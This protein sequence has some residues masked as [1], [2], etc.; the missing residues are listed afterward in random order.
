MTIKKQLKAFAAVLALLLTLCSCMNMELGVTVNPDGTVR[1]YTEMA[2][3]K[4]MLS[5]MGMSA[6]EFFEQIADS[7]SLEG[8]DQERFSKSIDGDEYVGIRYYKD[9][10]LDFFWENGLSDGSGLENEMSFQFEGEDLIVRIVYRNGDGGSGGAEDY[11]AQEMMK[12]KFRISTPFPIKETNGEIDGDGSVYWDLTDILVGNTDQLEMT[13]RFKVGSDIG[14]LF[15]SLFSDMDTEFGVTVNS[16]RTARAYT[17]IAIPKSVF[18]EI[19]LSEEEFF[20]L[21]GSSDSFGDWES[22]RFSKET[23]GREY[24]GIRYYKDSPLDFLSEN[25]L[26]GGNELGTEMSFQREGGDYLVRVLY[27]GGKTDGA[28]GYPVKGAKAKFRLSVPFPVAETNGVIGEDGSVC[29]D[30][31]DVFSGNADQL[32]MTARFKVGP[33]IGTILLIVGGIVLAAAV[34]VVVVLAVRNRPKPLAASA[35]TDTS[36]VPTETATAIPTPAPTEASAR[37]SEQAKSAPAEQAENSAENRFC[38]NCGAQLKEGD[39]FCASC[40]AKVN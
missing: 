21:I 36:Y 5:D 9:S 14:M 19:G 2:I 10:S 7:D 4:S 38:S 37:E 15:P 31:T 8:W 12:V 40:G 29:W 34:I 25:G 16:D 20:G 24:T 1:A 39:L 28:G 27:Q 22:E 13:V 30:L 11:A 17:E 23:D 18:G 6:E 33:D 3:K 35:R 26:S 32:E